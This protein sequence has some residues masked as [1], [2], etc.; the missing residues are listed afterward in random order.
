MEGKEKKRKNITRK[1]CSDRKNKKNRIGKE[2]NI[3]YKGGREWKFEECK[4]RETHKQNMK[5]NIEQES[6]EKKK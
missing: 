3:E 1:K 2:K 6:E 4:N 5:L